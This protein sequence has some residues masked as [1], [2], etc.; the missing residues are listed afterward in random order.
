M[1]RWVLNLLAVLIGFTV[2][3]FLLD[4]LMLQTLFSQVSRLFLTV[5]PYITYVMLIFLV[6]AG[7]AS[8]NLQQLTW[9]ALRTA[10]LWIVILLAAAMLT[11]GFVASLMPQFTLHQFTA[12]N[13]GAAEPSSEMQLV[14]QSAERLSEGAGFEVLYTSFGL[15]FPVILLSF[16]LGY[17]I[18]PVRDV[19]RPAYSVINSFSEVC[20]TL[21]SG[22]SHVLNIGLA[23]L[24]GLLFARLLQISQVALLL[25]FFIFL[26][27]AVL[28][29]ILLI[30]PLAAV[31]ITKEKHPYRLLFGLFSPVL[32]SLFS[33]SSTYALPI[34]LQHTRINLGTAKR[35]N[36]TALPV[37][38][39]FGRA[40]SA[41]IS[42][43]TLT[44]LQAAFI[45]EIPSPVTV[46]SIAVICTLFSL[47][48]YA[49]PG[50]EVAMITLGTAGVLNLASVSETTIAVLFIL[51]PL[52]QGLSAV[53]DTLACGVGSASCGYKL[54]AHVVVSRKERI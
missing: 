44:S 32:L 36:S 17:G 19:L 38:S 27:I 12:A 26:T 7:T 23:F 24:S 48:A 50:W 52:L 3:L 28:I 22:F 18:T 8:L 9:K 40:G 34:T 49:F 31:L 25:P 29:Y 14:L 11:G 43:F 53:I 16:V 46:L 54:K 37:I 13:P 33:G 51:Y 6:S 42:I 39:L 45:G 2:A 10:F 47:A 35:V 30:I 41:L 15:L 20:H 1:K 4:N 5:T 21:L